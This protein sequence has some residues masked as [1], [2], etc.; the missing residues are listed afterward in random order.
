[1][2]IEENI[3]AGFA[4]IAGSFLSQS[5]EHMVPWLIVSAAVVVCD[6]AFG[7]RKALIMGE[8]IRLSSAIRR[9]MGKMVTY[10]AFVCMIV[11]IDIASGMAWHIDIY[12]CLIVCFIELCI[13]LSNYL[14]H[15]GI[16]F[17]ILKA[18]AILLSKIFRLEKKDI[19]EVVTKEKK[20]E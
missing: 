19:E 12:S 3:A 14:R 8:E 7:I 11:M 5:L 10:F 2:T 9:T 13:I 15:K 1:M 18:V 16:N 6:L 17:N 20:Y 4:A